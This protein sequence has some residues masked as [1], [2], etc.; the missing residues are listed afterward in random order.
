MFCSIPACD[1]AVYSRDLCQMHYK[2]WLRHGEAERVLRNRRGR[3]ACLV[4]GCSK[5]VDARGLCHGHHQRLIRGSQRG[6]DE[7]LRTHGRERICSVATCGRPTHG[8]GL[9]KTHH[10]RLL[11]YGDVMAH[12]PIR[13]VGG[14]GHIHHGYREVPVPP[15][16]R[17]LT[18]GRTPYPEHRLVMAAALGRPLTA[19]ESV[20]HRNGIRTDNR[21]ENLE[22]WCRWQPSGQRVE[23]LIESAHRLIERYGRLRE[24][25]DS[26][27]T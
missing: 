24:E 7:P 13:A 16:L 4:H 8:R 23:D 17:H 22:L 12:K 1:R 26:D 25:E 27:L 10:S 3:G 18:N 5:K 6:H 11:R 14:T 19:R 20:H 21:L 2:R 15:E 9:C